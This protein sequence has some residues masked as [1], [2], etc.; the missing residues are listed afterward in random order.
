LIKARMERDPSFDPYGIEKARME[1]QNAPF[2]PE[3][4][5]DYLNYLS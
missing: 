5:L 3:A 2:D 4:E 1:I